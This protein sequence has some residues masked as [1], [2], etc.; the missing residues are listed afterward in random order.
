MHKEHSFKSSRAGRPPGHLRDAFATTVDL[1]CDWQDGQPEPRV[2]I[3]ERNVPAREIC[4]LLWN[5][6]DTM[7]TEV[8]AAIAQMVDFPRCGA[9]YA[10][11]ARAI[12]CIVSGSS[13]W[14]GRRAQ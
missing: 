11:G 2:Q 12:R 5:C 7:P 9:S 1:V 8:S 3:G 13:G 10:Q 14:H 6:T 4:G